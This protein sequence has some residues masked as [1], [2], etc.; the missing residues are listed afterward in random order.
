MPLAAV[1]A[2]VEGVGVLCVLAG[3]ARRVLE[4]FVS[5]LVCLFFGAKSRRE[6]D[7]RSERPGDDGR[8]IVQE[9]VS[10]KTGRVRCCIRHLGK[11]DSLLDVD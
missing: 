4:L 9:G 2:R 3:W 11:Q 6:K 7:E 8:Q 5:C 1:D 10:V